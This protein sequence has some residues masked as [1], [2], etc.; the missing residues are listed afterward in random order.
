MIKGPGEG[1]EYHWDK[2]NLNYF[3]EWGNGE[4][5]E[6]SPG[7]VV[8]IRQNYL[9]E[10]SRDHDEIKKKI[11]PVLFKALPAF[12]TK[13]QRTEANI[14]A[15][16]KQISDQVDAWFNL[17]GSKKDLENQLKQL[18]EKRTLETSKENIQS[19]I[20]ILKDKSKLSSEDL[21][22]YEKISSELT[23]L[24][25]KIKEVDEELSKLPADTEEGVYFS[26]VQ[27]RLSPEITNLPKN[28]Q[29][30]INSKLK[31]SKVTVLEDVNAKV[32]K[33]KD[34]AKEKKMSAEDEIGKIKKDNAPLIEKY[35]DNLDLENL[36]KKLNSHV[37][38]LKT[39]TETESEI[40]IAQTDLTTAETSIK[41][42]IEQRK[43][44][45]ENLVTAIKQEAVETIHGITFGLEYGFDN[46]F[47]NVTQQ[48]NVKENTDFVQGNIVKLDIIRQNP[49]KFLADIYSKK[50]KVMAR[51][52]GKEVVKDI[53][54]LTEK[55][56]FNAEMEGDKIGG[57]SESTMTAGKRALFA[58]RL[59]LAESDDAWPLLIDQPEDDLDS[60]SIYDEIVPFLKEKKKERQII[61]VSHNANL[62]IGADSEQLI[63]ANRNGND[64]KNS[65]GKQFNY[66]TG[67]LEFTRKKDCACGDILQSQGICEHA[68]EILD[69]GREAFENRKNRYNI[70]QQ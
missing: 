47:D 10:K 11:E 9:F 12:K 69:G 66:F 32:V 37:E 45:I 43:T 64:R 46:N 35:K 16:N 55:I 22:Q 7:N 53:L 61:M 15:L 1:E 3:V 62:V 52:D 51:Y 26:E 67:S 65:D 49:G 34:S 56:L 50:Q 31:D 17:A 44:L 54:S 38:T 33:Y 28:L 8:Y 40:T 21:T 14:K 39:I 42:A 18:G 58:L 63:V 2:I 36:I 57:F 24:V 48:L 60:R 29:S 41:N 5:N 68:C 25:S 59:I 20:Q 19:Q 6:K 4:S 30:I 13:Y 70:K 27:I 23:A